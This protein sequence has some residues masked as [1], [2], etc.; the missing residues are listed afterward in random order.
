MEL[1]DAIYKRKSVRKYSDRGLAE[2]TLKRIEKTI[3][4]RNKL[5]N[6]IQ[7]DVSILDEKTLGPALSGIVGSYGKVEAPHYIVASSENGDLHLENVG[8][9]LE[10]VVLHLTRNEIGSCWVGKGLDAEKY[11]SMVEM[12]DQLEPIIMIAFGYPKKGKDVWRDNENEAKRKGLD[13]I[14][15]HDKDRLSEEWKKIL[16]AA[17]MAPSAVNSQPWRFKKDGDRLHVYV[18]KKGGLLN[19]A[20]KKFANLEELNHI[21]VGI[22]LSHIKV[23]AQKMSKR[24]KIERLNDVEK[25]DH[26]YIASVKD[27]EG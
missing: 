7:T 21:D 2:D 4:L 20:M 8:Y 13:K 24:I 5:N 27:I 19:K 11:K 16:D 17:R 18:S 12:S 1:Y 14:L 15:L 6:E 26:E 10:P 3:D 22:A 9:S 25:E 23:A